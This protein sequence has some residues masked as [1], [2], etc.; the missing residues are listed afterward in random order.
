MSVIR[1]NTIINGTAALIPSGS[2]LILCNVGQDFSFEAIDRTIITAEIGTAAGQTQD[3]A[4]NPTTGFLFAQ[5]QGAEIRRVVG[6]SLV[7][8]SAATHTT[9]FQRFSWAI[10]AGTSSS[11]LGFAIVNPSDPSTTAGWNKNYSSLFLL[12]T[13]TG[14]SL[15]VNGDIVR[16]LV[17]LGSPKY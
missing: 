14:A 9:I 16:V 7:K 2:P 1:Q 6:V 5:F 8:S 3:T 11:N 13:G 10:G 12:D 4:S 15:I 17:E